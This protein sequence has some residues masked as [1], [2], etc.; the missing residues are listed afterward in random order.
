[1]LKYEAYHF[2]ENN[3]FSSFHNYNFNY[4]KNLHR[5]FEFVYVKKVVLKYV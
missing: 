2:G 5:S 1:M 3:L 4:T